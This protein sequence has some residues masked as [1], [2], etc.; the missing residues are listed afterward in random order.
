MDVSARDPVHLTAFAAQCVQDSRLALFTPASIHLLSSIAV[1]R[2]TLVE[3][4]CKPRSNGCYCGNDVAR[5]SVELKF[6]DFVDYYQAG[7]TREHSHW[8]QTVDDLDFYL[9]QCPIAV[10][11]SSAT[12]G[13]KAVLPAVANDVCIPACLGETH[14]TQVN[15]WMT[16]QPSRT[17]LHYDAYHNVLVV[18]YGRKMVT[19]YPPSETAKMYPFPVHSKSVNHSRVDAVQP[20][21]AKHARFSEAPAQQFTVMAGDALVIPEGWW[22]RVDSDQFTIA[23]NYW[24]N[25]VREQLVAD[26]RMVPYYARVM[27]EELVAQQCEAR[28]LAFRSS[29]GTGNAKIYEDEGEAVAAFFAAAD[30][31]CREQVMLSLESRMFLKMQEYL[32]T[33]HAAEWR[34]LLANASVNLAAALA[35]CWESDDSEPGV[36]GKLFVA[37][38]DEEE[39]IKETVAT[40]Q[41][42][43]RQDCASDMYR[44]LFG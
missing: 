43:F 26:K 29:S 5:Q 17:A 42:Q 33:N 30:Q 31:V 6:G 32:A 18:L 34:R 19:L 16:V 35:K 2:E 9:A 25:G 7:A 12:A 20:D 40:K 3:V 38:G 15:L 1:H 23:V 39:S 44:S 28:L 4:A 41:A 37:L 11:N 22:H 14:V 36:V 27:L 21:L 8:L 13:T 24:W 10:R